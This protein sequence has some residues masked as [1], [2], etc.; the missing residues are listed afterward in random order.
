ML[1]GNVSDSGTYR[2]EVRATLKDGTGIEVAA[3]S[4]SAVMEQKVTIL[5]A[6]NTLRYDANGGEGGPQSGYTGGATIKVS[7]AEPVRAHYDFIGWNT[8]A[9]G[10]GQPYN[11]EDEYTFTED[12]GNGGCVVTLYATWQLKKYPVTFRIDGAIASTETVEHGSDVRLPEI[13]AKKGFAHKWDSDGKNITGET[14]ITAVYTLI[15]VVNP[16]ELSSGDKTALESARN[17]LET[18]LENN[19]GNYTDEQKSALREEIG[20]ITDALSAIDQAL[21]VDDMVAALPDHLIPG[22]KADE[23]KVKEANAAYEAL[24]DRAQGLLRS[25]TKEKLQALTKQLHTDCDGTNLCPSLRFEDLKTSAWY[26]HSVDFVIAN[27]YMCGDPD[28]AFRPEEALTRGEMAQILYN[29]AGRPRVNGADTFADTLDGAWYTKAILWCAQNGLIVGYG[30]GKFGPDDILTRE[31]MITVLY[32]YDLYSGG[33]E[34]QGN[35]TLHYSDASKVSVWARTAMAWA[36]AGD[37]IN[38]KPGNLLNPTGFATRAQTATV[39]YKY[40]GI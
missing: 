21:A 4:V 27:G 12:G 10:S 19:V 14:T 8:K 23:N 29:L 40:N 20:R 25:E 1:E 17:E 6:S 16:E 7:K 15:P 31:Q 9:D 30:N 2:V 5:H 28:G 11:A 35:T 34:F 39:L 37:I 33:A 32:R 13:P 3:T 36:D 18:A 22:S 38:G 26:H 24:S